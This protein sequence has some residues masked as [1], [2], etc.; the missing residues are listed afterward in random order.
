[1][2]VINA[3]NEFVILHGVRTDGD[4]TFRYINH[5]ISYINTEIVRVRDKD[6]ETK[7]NNDELKQDTKLFD[8]L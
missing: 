5:Y 1:V 6:S 7:A 8:K 4:L 2:A 3:A